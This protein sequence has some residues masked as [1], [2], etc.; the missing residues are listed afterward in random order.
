MKYLGIDYGKTKIGTAYSE[1]EIASAGETI[2]I[3]GLQDA[4]TKV[5]QII[6]VQKV[7]TVVIGKPESGESLQYEQNFVAE[8]KKQS[9]VGIVEVDETLSTQRARDLML[10]FNIP[11]R[12]RRQEDAHSAA[13]ILQEYLDNK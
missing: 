8:L 3:N 2:R 6:E 13:L 4:L 1:G 5:I 9:D 7:E 11:P 12:K 10:Q